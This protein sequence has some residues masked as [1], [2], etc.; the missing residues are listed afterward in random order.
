MLGTLPG[1]YFIEFVPKPGET[2]IIPICLSS[3]TAGVSTGL[4]PG[5]LTS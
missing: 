4:Q 2:L 5:P 1:T 3:H